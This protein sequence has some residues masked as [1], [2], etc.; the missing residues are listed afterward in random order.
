MKDKL[1]EILNFLKSKKGENLTY[2]KSSL[3]E[4]AKK[5]LNAANTDK[6]IVVVGD[7]D[8]DGIFSSFIAWHFL[9]ALYHKMGNSSNVELI[10][11]NRDSGFGITY[12]EYQKLSNEYDLIITTDMGSDLPFLSQ[13]IENLVVIDH[14]PTKNNY[15]YIINPNIQ[16]SNISTSG[17]RVVYDIIEKLLLPNAKKI[18]NLP[19]FSPPL[20]AY[21]QLAAVTL[22]SDMANLTQNNREFIINALNDMK[23]RV[24]VPMFSLLEEFNSLEIS[25]KIVSPIN[26]YSRMEKN[27]DDI[28]QF[29]NPASFKEF[30]EAHK[31]LQDNNKE[32][33]KLVNYYYLD[34]IG[35]NNNK[36]KIENEYFLFYFN[37]EMPTGL[38][39]LI[40]NK[41]NS[42][43]H[44]VSIIA[45]QRNDEIVG[46][47]RGF[48]VKNLFYLFGIPTLE[49]GGH[50]DA[51]GFK[52]KKD[53]LNDFIKKIEEL[54]NTYHFEKQKFKAIIDKPLSMKEVLELNKL[55]AQESQGV[56]FQEKI[57]Y[58]FSAELEIVGKFKNDYL[59]V[60]VGDKEH[61]DNT[62]MSLA[63]YEYLK[64]KKILLGTLRTDGKIHIITGVNNEIELKNSISLFETEKIKI[65]KE[66]SNLLN[67]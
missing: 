46:S 62:L 50:N 66:N 26:A 58:P 47:A 21:A 54:A 44:K 7:Y 43:F 48:N 22:I 41:I 27:L 8:V 10:F 13:D 33:I 17:G 53:F 5:I 1:R 28:K 19:E 56:D 15:D 14:H 29:I 16:R 65:E 12:E 25:Y 64:N 61:N 36:N 32:K 35:N 40:A 37:P 34:I 60:K 11:S 24:I 31:K 42:S 4:G 9:Y 63:E 23:E 30:K 2:K 51:C 38:N 45:S 6:K 39:G 59:L 67:M 57:T 3:I 55:Y 20:N 49:F 52:L 18:F